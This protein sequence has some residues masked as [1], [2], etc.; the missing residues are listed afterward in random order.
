MK[1]L[2]LVA[3]LCVGLLFAQI[4][5]V[6]AP[7]AVQPAD[8]E[9]SIWWGPA[10]E[11]RGV[12]LPDLAAGLSRQSQEDE[13]VS[14]FDEKAGWMIQFPGNLLQPDEEGEGLTVFIADDRATFVA[15]DSYVESASRRSPTADN[16]RMRSIET[17]ARIYGR[18]IIPTDVVTSPPD[19]WTTGVLFIT[20]RGSKGEAIYKLPSRVKDTYRVY[21]IIYGY[22]AADEED[23]LP[24]LQAVRDSFTELPLPEAP[25][26]PAQ[27]RPTPTPPG[28]SI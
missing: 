28:R 15:V 25:P 13:V 8:A 17:L 23:V 26:A 16:L 18:R 21:G 10:V 2:A 22:K 19:G 11:E 27:P 24:I 6:T 3:L 1:R 20:D 5:A 14:F 9:A 4:M 7:F 12:S